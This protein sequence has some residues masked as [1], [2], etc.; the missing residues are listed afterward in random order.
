[1]PNLPTLQS[2]RVED[3]IKNINKYHGSFFQR[4]DSTTMETGATDPY[5]EVLNICKQHGSASKAIDDEQLFF[6]LEKTL[7]A[8]QM[9]R[10]KAGGALETRSEMKKS[11]RSPEIRRAIESV[12]F[13]SVAN[14]LVIDP[15]VFQHIEKLMWN[16]RITTADSKIVANSK[17]LHFLMPELI[18][19]IDRRYTLKF[20][21]N[22]DVS[23]DMQKEAFRIIYKQFHHIARRA[24][25]QIKR[26]VDSHRF[27]T[28]EAKVIDNAIIGYCLETGL[29]ENARK[30]SHS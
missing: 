6:W 19:P 23:P 17:T 18:P 21:F 30:R 3:L 1:M 20:F 24:S 26:L 27:A 28:S 10:G 22:R 8:W 13:L 4:V 12:Q 9:N 11:L 25:S 14:P 29:V 2:E 16:I 5:F 15:S 7:K